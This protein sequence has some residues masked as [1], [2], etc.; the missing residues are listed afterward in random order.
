MAVFF[1]A[2]IG[3]FFNKD[4]VPVAIIIIAI[5][6]IMSSLR[7]RYVRPR[8]AAFQPEQ[9]GPSRES[10]QRLR[11]EVESAIVE[12]QDLSRRISSEIDVRFAR[13]EAAIHDADRRIAA[14]QRL[15]QEAEAANAAGIQQGGASLTGGDEDRLDAR[16][17]VVY[18]MADGG[19]TPV[20]IARELGKTP[21]E[22]ELILNLRRSS[23]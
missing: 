12:L 3:E 17:A 7:R 11:A 18:E 19:R 15:I 2:D 9:G 1:P 4:Y 6:L 16:Y 5:V 10:V 13:L 21:G 22:V 14:L 8:T 20:E 23:G